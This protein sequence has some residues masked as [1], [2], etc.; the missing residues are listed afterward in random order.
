MRN[1]VLLIDIDGGRKSAIKI[2]HVERS[3]KNINPTD[4]NFD[5]VDDMATLCEA[6]C[7][8][9]HA[10]ESS[11]VKDSASSLRSCIKHL[12]DGF[13]DETYFAKI[14]DT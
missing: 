11:G 4:G 8:L 6:I 3:G 13:V 9:I 12:E 1:K 5:V 10:A 14:T 7:T 2:I